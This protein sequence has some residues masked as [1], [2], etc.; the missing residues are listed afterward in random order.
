MSGEIDY[1]ADSK[2][3][4]CNFAKRPNEQL[5]EISRFLDGIPSIM[6]YRAFDQEIK[7]SGRLKLQQ[8]TVTQLISASNCRTVTGSSEYEQAWKLRCEG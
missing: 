1:P 4:I 7:E 8:E 6:E 2:H 5:F 3:E